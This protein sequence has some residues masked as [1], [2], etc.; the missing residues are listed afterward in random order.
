MNVTETTGLMGNFEEDSAILKGLEQRAQDMGFET[1]E[2]A[3]DAV[4]NG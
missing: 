4:S 2:D 1:I 3:L